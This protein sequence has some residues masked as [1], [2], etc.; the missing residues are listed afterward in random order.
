LGWPV[1]IGGGTEAGAALA[2]ARLLDTGASGLVSFGLAGGLDP[3]LKPG[4]L[5]VPAKVLTESGSFCAAPGLAEHFGGMGGSGIWGGSRVA[6][7]IGDKK[8]LFLRSGAVAIDL[9]SGAV[10]RAAH[11]R[12]V[13]FV[14]V[15]AICDPADR[16]LPSAALVALGSTGG[17]GLLRVMAEVLRHPGQVPALLNLAFDA[18]K[19]RAALLSVARSAAPRAGRM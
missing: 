12:G 3:A 13:P 4:D 1:E 14:A 15:R 11:G 8:G 18:A 2:A 5:L 7:T 17:I 19:A 10:A 9:E 16:D 6:A